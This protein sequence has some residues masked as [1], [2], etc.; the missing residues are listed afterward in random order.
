[1]IGQ[2]VYCLVTSNPIGMVSKNVSIGKFL[3]GWVVVFVSFVFCLAW[4]ILLFFL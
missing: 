2:A 3:V 4:D 1:M